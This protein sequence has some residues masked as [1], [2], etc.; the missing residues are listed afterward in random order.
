MDHNKIAIVIVAYNRLDPFRRLLKSIDNI[1]T[2]H[3]NIPL[4]ISIDYSNDNQKIINYAEEFIWNFGQKEILKHKEK[5]GLKNHIINSGNLSK[6]YKGV[7]ILEDDLFVSPFFYDY[8]FAACN[9]Y[10]DELNIAGISLY[11]YE[12][13]ES[14]NFTFKPLYDKYDSYFIQYPSSWG[15][16]WLNAHWQD[17]TRWLADIGDENKINSILPDYI[18]IWPETSWK[19]FFAAYLID[20]NKYFVYP[21]IGLSTNFGEVGQHH[22]NQLNIR[23]VDLLSK[24]MDFNF[25][26]FN[27][28]CAKYDVAFELNYDE[29]VKLNPNL[30]NLQKFEIDFYCKKKH[31]PNDLVLTASK[32]KKSIYSF[33]NKLIPPINNLIFDIPGDELNISKFKYVIP[34]HLG[35]YKTS[36]FAEFKFLC[37]E[38]LKITYHNFFINKR[39]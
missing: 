29:L 30:K 5:L 13:A 26:R 14:A 10:K 1:I 25:S 19:K 38:I 37:R 17:F 7:I 12:R 35:V 36:F 22:I 23:Q 20:T 16:C 31:K 27:N 24:K 34:E 18:S 28:S 33:S 6:K 15:Q 4:L 11:S 39:K 3:K 9:F 32:S 8:T 21:K 2:I